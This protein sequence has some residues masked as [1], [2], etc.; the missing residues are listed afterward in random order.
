[1]TIILRTIAA[2]KNNKAAI[3]KRLLSFEITRIK[4]AA[5]SASKTV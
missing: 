3:F 4:I 2:P 5:T 1:M